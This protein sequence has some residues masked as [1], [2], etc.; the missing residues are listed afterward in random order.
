MDKIYPPNN[1]ELISR[2]QFFANVSNATNNNANDIDGVG[3]RVSAF[4]KTFEQVRD[5]VRTASIRNKTLIAAAVVVWTLLGSAVGIY[6][7]RGL[8]TFDK[9][10][11]RIETIEKK[12]VLLEGIND[13]R[14]DVPG[15]VDA[16][17]RQLA[18]LQRKVDD[19]EQRNI[20]KEGY[21]R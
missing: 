11:E 21:K 15:K 10:S 20:S 8:S 18:E 3:K 16:I 1:D 2:H 12:I 9:A 17:G 7:Q 14:K 19:N 6:I 4:A 13:Q 5:D